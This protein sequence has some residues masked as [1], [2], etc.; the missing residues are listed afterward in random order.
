MNCFRSPVEGAPPQ[1]DADR[2]AEVQR[3]LLVAKAERDEARQKVLLYMQTH[4]DPR[5]RISRNK[6][7]A[8]IGAMQVEPVRRALEREQRRLD[9][10]FDA[11]LQE[12]ANLMLKLGKIQ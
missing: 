2:L 5:I 12:R 9:Q 6:L 1:I 4:M 3:E 8:T 7:F 10:R 11:L